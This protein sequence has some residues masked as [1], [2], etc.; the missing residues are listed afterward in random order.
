M[1]EAYPA[2]AR[3]VFNDTFLRL[4]LQPDRYDVR[5]PIRDEPNA[6]S[7]R[8]LASQIVDVYRTIIWNLGDQN[9]AEQNVHGGIS[10]ADAALLVTFL[11]SSS[12]W[13]PGLYASG[14]NFAASLMKFRL[15]NAVFQL[16]Q[17]LGMW[18]ADYDYDHTILGEPLSPL[19]VAAPGSIFDHT[20]DP[21]PGHLDDFIASNYSCIELGLF[22][23][24]LPM[25]GGS[26]AMYYSNN[27]A[28]VAT[29]TDVNTNGVRTSRGVIDGFSFERILDN[30][31]DG[32]PDR[33][34]HLRDILE[35]L[36]GDTVT[37]TGTLHTAPYRN[38]LHQN[39]PNPFNPATTIQFSI[40]K[41][42]HVTLRVYNVS[43]QLVRTLVD[44]DMAPRAGSYAVEWDGRNDDG[45]RVASGIYFYRV[46][47][48]GF[49]NTRK[50]VLLK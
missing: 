44:D 43:G 38:S 15:N 42:G 28:H 41:R 23:V 26:A 11:D 39:Y 45:V 16:I 5:E 34:E 25:W 33:V 2:D 19:V 27:P 13:D 46:T 21:P 29:I 30:D 47:A 32:V 14:N 9:G 31:A 3:S 8:A 40:A 36:R 37:V 10:A 20:G 22:D 1:N 17:R 24:L 50:M 7:G 4:G 49:V 35:F 6:L 18:F 48:T 12:V